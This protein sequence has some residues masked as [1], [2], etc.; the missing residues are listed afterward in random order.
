MKHQPGLNMYC[1]I[2]FTHCTCMTIHFNY[3]KIVNKILTSFMRSSLFLVVMQH[4]YL[5]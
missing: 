2:K 3:Q 4:M 1:G 5:F